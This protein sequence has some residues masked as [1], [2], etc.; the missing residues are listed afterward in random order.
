MAKACILTYGC[1]MNV[2]D[3]EV[4]AGQLRELG[5][6]MVEDVE[7]ADAVFVNTCSVREHAKSRALARISTLTSLKQRRPGVFLAAV[8]CVATEEGENLRRRI[9]LLDAIIPTDQITNI[10]RFLPEHDSDF[11]GISPVSPGLALSADTP[12]LRFSSSRAYVAVATGCNL[13]CTYCIVPR[14][15]GPEKSRALEDVMREVSDLVS[16]GY[17]EITFLG[18]VV[19]AYGGTAP[20]DS[21]VEI[22]R[23][24]DRIFPNGRIRFFS[25]HPL[26]MTDEL[27][28]E[29]PHLSCLCNHVHLPVQSGSDKILRMMNR[30]YTRDEY[31]RKVEALRRS[32]PG[33]AITT[34]IIVGFPGETDADYRATL[35]LCE[36]VRFDAAFMF[37]YSPRSGTPAARLRETTPPREK[38]VER[39]D[40]LMELQALHVNETLRRQIGR[41]LEV[42][43]ETSSK[44]GGILGKSRE[45]YDV[46]VDLPPQDV[47]K[48]MRVKIESLA[49]KTLLGKIEEEVVR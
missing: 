40:E 19:N 43:M 26:K 47:G 25:A 35:S 16:R 38:S 14:T 24:T 8:G 27:I 17:R 30:L 34:D 28:S 49:G 33:I 23:R 31:L 18:Q 48:V 32:V 37:I 11:A 36:Q 5:Y 10:A 39:L 13:A 44:D 6:E 1:Q 22:L 7:Q 2:H 9:P 12:H 21:F 15:R 20:G 4:V 3:S 45:F 41:T 46:V 29:W 42:L